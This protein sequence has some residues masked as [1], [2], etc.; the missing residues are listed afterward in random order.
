MSPMMMMMMMMMMTN[1]RITHSFQEDLASSDV[2]RLVLE[3]PAPPPGSSHGGRCLSADNHALLAPVGNIE[4]SRYYRSR[5]SDHPRLCL[6]HFINGFNVL[7][8]AGTGWLVLQGVK[9]HHLDRFEMY[10]IWVKRFVV[11]FVPPFPLPLFP[12]SLL[13]VSSFRSLFVLSLINGDC[14]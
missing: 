1:T 12:L 3:R 11:I 14:V 8:C 7:L 13:L 9:I 5:W 2:G 6:S 10:W 4:L